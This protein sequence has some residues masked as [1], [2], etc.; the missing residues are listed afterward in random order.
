MV[1]RIIAVP[2]GDRVERHELRL[3]VGRE[4]RVGRGA[5]ADG[6]EPAGALRRIASRSDTTS[7]PASISLSM[8]ASR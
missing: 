7:Q 2:F 3:H 8:T 1:S 5:Q 4:G 6:I